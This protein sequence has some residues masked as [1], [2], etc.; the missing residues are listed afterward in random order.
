MR[1]AN[2]RDYEWLRVKKF[3]AVEEGSADQEEKSDSQVDAKAEPETDS[4]ADAD[5]PAS[6]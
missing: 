5:A 4:K 1:N 3:K 6:P 2:N